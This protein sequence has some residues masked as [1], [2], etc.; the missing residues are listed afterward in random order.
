MK[1]IWQSPKEH[2]AS[3]LD[4]AKDM[5][6]LSAYTNLSAIRRFPISDSLE[7]IIPVCQSTNL[8][9]LKEDFSQFSG[10]DCSGG[11]TAPGQSLTLNMDQTALYNNIRPYIPESL[12]D[13][14]ITI[15]RKTVRTQTVPNQRGKKSLQLRLGVF[16][17]TVLTSYQRMI[18]GIHQSYKILWTLQKCAIKD[19]VLELLQSHYR[20]W[21]RLFQLAIYHIIKLSCPV[22]T[23]IRQLSYRVTFNHP[24]PEPLFFFGIFSDLV[25]PPERASATRTKPTL[26]SF[27]IMPVSSNLYKTV[28]TGFFYS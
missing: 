9:D 26:F 11:C 15:N 14:G 18:T 27:I 23:L 8:G 19:K 20:R 22:F 13:L 28:R 25:T 24:K 6:S 17:N 12:N 4:V 21:D 16:R 2:A 3:S 7:K 10:I 5:A 1:H